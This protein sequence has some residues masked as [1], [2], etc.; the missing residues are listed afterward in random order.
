MNVKLKVFAWVIVSLLPQYAS[1]SLN[2][3]ELVCAS[4]LPSGDAELTWV[5][6][7]DPTGIFNQYQVFHAPTLAG[8]FTQIGTVSTYLTNT[9]VHVGAMADQSQQYYFVNVLDVGP[10]PN[11]SVDSDTLATLFLTVAQSVPL[12]SALLNWNTQHVPAIPASTQLYQVWLEYPVGVWNVIDTTVYTVNNFQH[13]ITICSDSLSFRIG[14][15]SAPGCVSFSNVTGDQ[16]EDV[17][18][19][20]VPQ[21]VAA[22]VDTATGLA[23]FK[24][25]PSPE[26]D[27]DGYIIVNVIG[28]GNVIIDTV[29]GQF[30]TNYT[31]VN[32]DPVLG[33][34]AYTV[35][36]FD[37]CFSGSP[38]QPNTSATVTG[39]ATIHLQGNY[40][41]CV[42]E[43]FLQW[44]PYLGWDS[45]PEYELY[46]ELNDGSPF[47]LANIPAGQL[48]YSDLGT[49]PFNDYCYFIKAIGQDSCEV[50]FSNRY[51]V[52]T[53]FPGQP[54]SNYIRTA[55]VVSEDHIRIVD[56]VDQ[57]ALVSGYVLERAENDGPFIPVATLP[58]SAALDITFDDIGV[59]ADKFSY[60]YQIMVLDSCGNES[61]L[62]NEAATVWLRT[63]STL[64]GFN[65][66]NWNGYQVWAGQ[67]G[68]YRVYRS[69]GGE[70]FNFLA[71]VP[72]GQ[73]FFDDDVNLFTG[74]RGDFCYYVEA[75][76]AGNPFAPD[77]LS[78]SNV[79]CTVQQ[80]L[81]FIPNAFVAG[82]SGQNEEFFAVSSF[83]DLQNLEFTIFNRWG[84]AVWHTDDPEARWDGKVNGEFVP[85]GVYAYFFIY[86]TGSGQRVEK[87]GTVTFIN[88]LE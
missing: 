5:I 61:F 62:S 22:S 25:D 18:A 48:F 11:L 19:P 41:Q 30:N 76:E 1:A 7:P 51:C 35:A 59:E 55:T 68:G 64:D 65:H 58:A 52:T 44:S 43:V 71:A 32:G 83:A 73:W 78:R 82:G 85:Q 38:P 20:T 15:E 13:V 23:N 3:P 88:L 80:D 34:L 74:A 84:K 42:P 56:R 21:V 66:L 4:V 67:V 33:S 24:W 72:A 39:Q 29:F 77:T 45:V 87:K 37:T 8:P 86:S 17:T 81:V 50:S 9:F 63:N 6:P 28:T 27:T 49:I 53:D 36:A 16:F 79:S 2:A 75:V 12:G 54:V 46:V 69:I 31:D 60:R 26:P 57:T 14:I 10:A 40:D 70:P 47:L